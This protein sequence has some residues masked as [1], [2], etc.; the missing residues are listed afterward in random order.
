MAAAVEQINQ[1]GAAFS[2][3]ENETF[4]A[5]PAEETFSASEQVIYRDPNDIALIRNL[6][7]VIL[8]QAVIALLLFGALAY[9]YV[10]TPD[11]IL[12]VTTPDG[13]RVVEL[14][15]RQYG[16]V[17]PV[18]LGK[19]HLTNEDKTAL[20]GEFCRA[21]YL[22]DPARR[23]YD[24]ERALKVMVTSS[25]VK[26]ADWLKTSGQ[27]QKEKDERQQSTW[28]VQSLKVDDRDPHLIRLI[29]TQ[30][31]T[32]QNGETV[33]KEQIQWNLTFKLVN[34]APRSDRNLRTGFLIESFDGQELSR[35][36]VN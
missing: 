32:R 34:D 14:N 5:S 23:A 19:D 17:E 12:A 27:L 8:I 35:S 25:A 18:V 6:L 4:E 11:R 7:I 26:Y 28:E 15:N 2:S 9:K 1:S 24:I 21:I 3:D 10:Q 16:A 30:V 20:V 29:G 33:S 13:Q 31:I 22:I 36:P